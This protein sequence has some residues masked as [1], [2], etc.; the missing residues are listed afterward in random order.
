MSSELVFAHQ[1]GWDEAL[2]V[3]G[4]LIIIGGLLHLANRRLKKRLDALDDG[5]AAPPAAESP[6][7]DQ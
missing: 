3:V 1:G 5:R 4:P 2:L 6:A 7:V